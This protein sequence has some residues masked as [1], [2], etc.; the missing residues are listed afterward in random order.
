MARKEKALTPMQ[1]MQM[2]GKYMN[3][4]LYWTTTRCK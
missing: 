4:E 3:D 2:L 1:R